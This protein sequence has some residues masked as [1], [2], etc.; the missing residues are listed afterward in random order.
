[1]LAYWVSFGLTVCLS[2]LVPYL[3]IE[4]H[5]KQNS[6]LHYKYIYIHI[7]C[8]CI[9]KSAY[10]SQYARYL[11]VNQQ[12]WRRLEYGKYMRKSLFSR[13][14]TVVKKATLQSGYFSEAP[15]AYVYSYPAFNANG[16]SILT[17]LVRW[18]WWCVISIYPLSLYS[19]NFTG[20]V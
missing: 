4:L 18:W 15:V 1:M 16:T 12:R 2:V 10:C 14:R 6:S 20:L 17:L 8:I 9:W 11:Y 7:M 13:K 19:T 5:Y 3:C